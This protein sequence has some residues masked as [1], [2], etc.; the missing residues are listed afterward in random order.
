MLVRSIVTFVLVFMALALFLAGSVT[1]N[2]L[3][4]G[5]EL[6]LTGVGF[7]MY[8]VLGIAEILFG[9]II[10]RIWSR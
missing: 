1:G 8:L 9:Y 2:A 7:G 4:N 10:Y 3:I 6:V 5:E